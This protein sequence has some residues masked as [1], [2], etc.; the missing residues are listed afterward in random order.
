ML[1]FVTNVRFAMKKIKELTVF[2]EDLI[3]RVTMNQILC[4]EREQA[5]A[6][7]EQDLAELRAEKSTIVGW[8]DASTKVDK[9]IQSQRFSRTMFGISFSYKKADPKQDRSMLKF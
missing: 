8:C 1:I 9:T 5:I 3:D 4:V 2:E 7:Q 6:E